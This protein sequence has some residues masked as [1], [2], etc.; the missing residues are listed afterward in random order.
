L[1][2]CLANPKIGRKVRMATV[3]VNGIVP[4]KNI[5]YLLKYDTVYGQYDKTV[6][7]DGEDLII[8]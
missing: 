2:P 6:E 5:I 1:K 8:G 4:I 7:G 3:A